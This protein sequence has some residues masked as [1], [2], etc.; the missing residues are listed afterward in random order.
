MKQAS[1]CV[2][3]SIKRSLLRAAHVRYDVLMTNSFR[4]QQNLVRSGVAVL[5]VPRLVRLS[6]FNCMYDTVDYSQ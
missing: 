5:R 4:Y 3:S 1:G 6:S 2:I